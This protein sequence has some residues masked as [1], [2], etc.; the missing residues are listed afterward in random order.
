MPVTLHAPPQ[1]VESQRPQQKKLT[2]EECDALEL[3]GLLEP[4]RYELIEGVLVGKMGKNAHHIRALAL[5]IE[6]LHQVFGARYVVQ[7]A[8]VDVSPEDNPTSRP[9]PDAAVLSF[10]VRDLRGTLR[11]IQV[12][13]VI[14]VSDTTLGFD[15]NDKA[16]LYAR[17]GIPEYWV[18]DING[19]QLFVYREPQQGKYGSLVVCSENETVTSLAA[20]DAAIRVGDIV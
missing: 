20:P 11:A 9:E 8:P 13:L 3:A 12:R 18:L 17:A 5:L 7:E 4:G 6:W 2:R 10:S 16:R 15:L 19:R 1:S 14:E